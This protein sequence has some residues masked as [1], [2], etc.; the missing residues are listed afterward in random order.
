M[1]SN[2]PKY[3]YA[4]HGAKG[5]RVGQAVSDILSKDQPSYTVG[6]ILDGFG[7]KF[8]IELEKTIE[9]NKS[10]YTAI[11]YVL[12]LTK[13]EYWADNVVRN[14]FVARQTAPYALDMMIQYPGYTKTLYVVN[15]RKGDLKV[16][17]SIPGIEDCKSIL[18]SPDTFSFEL[19]KWIRDCFE[20]KLDLDNYDHLF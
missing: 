13:K 20:G 8:A 10:K 17:W 11:F 18:K 5:A 3:Y 9:D 14:W 6:D 12:A 7:S 4:K 15:S 16:A 19:V 2:D 1:D